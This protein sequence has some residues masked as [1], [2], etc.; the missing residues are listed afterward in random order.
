MVVENFLVTGGGGDIGAATCK[1]LAE[2]GYRPIVAYRRNCPVAIGLAERFGGRPIALDLTDDASIMSAVETL[3]AYPEPLAGVIL[4]ASPA[5]VIAPFG[6]ITAEDMQLQWQVNV[7]GPQR[8]LAGLVR[9]SLRKRK[10]GTVIG[11]LSEA[12]G[13]SLRPTASSMGAYVIA[14][15]GLAGLLSV[16]AADYP[17]LR[18][19]SVSP[20]Y[21]Q[22]KML[23]A[24]DQRFLDLMRAKKEF[25]TPEEVAENIIQEIQKP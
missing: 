22:T 6:K 16:L 19:G 7:M 9:S 25:L 18:V 3:A 24:F 14:K 11:I 21:T 5:P 17:W 2:V 10:T 8:L 1:R 4:A 15:F 23:Q 20:G 12:M 13:D